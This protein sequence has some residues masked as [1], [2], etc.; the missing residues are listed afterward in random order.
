MKIYP[1]LIEVRAT[2]G[3]WARLDCGSEPF[4]EI[5]P[6]PSSARGLV[7][8]IRWVRPVHTEIVGSALCFQPRH[9]SYAF[10][11]RSPER[12]SDQIKNDHALQIRASVLVDPIYQ[13]LGFFS[14]KE[15]GKENLAHS[16]QSQFARAIK[17][18]VA[19]H[20]PVMGWKDFPLT[21][22]GLP[23]TNI[24]PMNVEIPVMSSMVYG[25]DGVSVKQAA[26]EIKDGVCQY[27]QFG[28]RNDSGRLQFTD[29]FLNKELDKFITEAT[30]RKAAA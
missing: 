26:A 4:S 10:N 19:F 29:E 8:S 24:L 17:R 15:E 11:S 23:Q 18:G 30:A 27:G 7:E 20:T 13:I 21:Y 5:V 22:F 14:N 1:F 12:K 6:S 25:A 2:M 3:M 9:T 16:C 28:C